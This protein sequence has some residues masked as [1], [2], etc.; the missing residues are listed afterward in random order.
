MKQ[1][2]IGIGVVICGFIILCTD[3]IVKSVIG[4]MPDVHFVDGVGVFSLS[5]VGCNYIGL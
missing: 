3:Y 4:A 5:A 1:L 2:M